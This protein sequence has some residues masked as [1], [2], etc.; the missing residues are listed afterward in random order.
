MEIGKG[1]VNNRGPVVPVYFYKCI[2]FTY[3]F[4][5]MLIAKVLAS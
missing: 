5:A 2:G 1:K 3:A 4:M